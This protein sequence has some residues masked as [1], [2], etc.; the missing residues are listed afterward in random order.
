MLKTPVVV[1]GPIIEFICVFYS[2]NSAKDVVG[3]LKVLER[4]TTR[5][6]FVSRRRS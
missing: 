3:S 2:V 1:N 6:S 4:V 5:C